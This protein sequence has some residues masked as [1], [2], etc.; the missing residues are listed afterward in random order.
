M[1]AV[2]FVLLLSKV[3]IEVR[4]TA[5][6]ASNTLVFV[7]DGIASI[8]QA[9]ATDAA[10]FHLD[11]NLLSYKYDERASKLMKT[12]IEYFVYDEDDITQNTNKRVQR[13]IRDCEESM[14]Y[15]GT[16][17]SPC[18]DVMSEQYVLDAL[19]SH[20]WRVKTS[21]NSD[22]SSMM[23][24]IIP[25]P[26]IAMMGIGCSDIKKF[27][28]CM[29]ILLG[30]GKKGKKHS[31]YDR[32]FTALTNHSRFIN[33]DGGKYH[34]VL[35][36]H[37][38]LFN[39]HHSYKQPNIAKWYGPLENITLAHHYDA[40]ECQNIYKE[41]QRRA[42]SNSTTNI[43]TDPVQPHDYT[44]MFEARK[45]VVKYL[46][47]LGIGIDLSMP[48]QI[49]PTIN[50][51]V[52]SSSS[53]WG[54]TENES[55]GATLER[56]PA[57]GV[58][59]ASTN[60]ASSIEESSNN[61]RYFIF[62]HASDREFRY[63]TTHYRMA[64]I[65]KIDTIQ[66]PIFNSTY[67]SFGHGLDHTTWVEYIS[68]SSFC[69]IMR[70]DTPHSH[71]LIR[72]IRAG[73]MPVVISDYYQRFASS[74]ANIMSMDEYCIFISEQEFISNPTQTLLKLRDLPKELLQQKLN[75]LQFAQRVLFPDHP[76]SLFVPAFLQQTL[77]ANRRNWWDN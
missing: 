72:S 64:P 68:K 62:Y 3:Y 63:N 35:S 54:P 76:E 14:L 41:Y 20:P 59:L 19:Q 57:G 33:Q 50:R 36:I 23:I 42:N 6:F 18:F 51:Y 8:R 46:F 73:C 25:T 45:P 71:S 75:G 37:Y 2:C 29:N 47:V 11:D 39:N 60:K 7:K 26:V 70:G 13:V 34:V 77:Y 69:L 10:S 67:S 28:S 21:I 52:Q 65:Y 49:P 32:P 43:D 61:N 53:T 55:S 9:D 24:H 74:F 48:L 22:S 30:K 12:K 66:H 15:G 58:E 31:V 17:I 27:N 1:V 56:E 4:A 5:P 38:N 44:P 40:I 16:Y